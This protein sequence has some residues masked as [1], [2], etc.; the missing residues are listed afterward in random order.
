MKIHNT[1]TNS[2]EEFIPIEENKVKMYVCGPTVYDYP[3]LGH[4]R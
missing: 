4:A 1:Y 3:H 2:I